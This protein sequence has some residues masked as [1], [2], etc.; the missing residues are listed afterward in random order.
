MAENGRSRGVAGILLTGGSSRR[1]GVAKTTLLIGGHR[2]A[3]RIGSKVAIVASPVVE[4][5]PGDSGLSAVREEP[6][7]Q[8]PLVAVVAGWAELNRVGHRGPVLIVAGDLPLVTVDILRL[9]ANWPTSGSVV[10]LV[11]GRRQ[12]LCARWSVADLE[13]A[14]T[15]AASGERAL[16]NCFGEDA[17]FLH[18]DAWGHLTEGSAF[19]DVD[20]PEDLVRL[21]IVPTGNARGPL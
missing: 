7:G 5:G 21:G 16:R 6:S 12:P 11:G 13:Q 9:V 3:E 1:M 20:T 17:V 18:K 10:P 8:G 15:A 19:A 2:L 14:V 4:V